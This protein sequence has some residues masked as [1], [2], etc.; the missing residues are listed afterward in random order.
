MSRAIWVRELL[1][2]LRNLKDKNGRQKYFVRRGAINWES[3]EWILPFAV[4]VRLA[5][6]FPARA[7]EPRETTLSINVATTLP[8]SSQPE[9]LHDETLE[10]METD[11]VNAVRALAQATR[12]GSVDHLIFG[13]EYQGSVE[14]HSTDFSVQGYV[15]TFTIDY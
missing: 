2:I 4:S 13:T 6:N 1:N 10:Q 11:M 14:W 3:H 15:V 5:E 9:N 8:S 12:Q 7:S